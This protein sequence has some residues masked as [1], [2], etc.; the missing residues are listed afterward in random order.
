MIYHEIHHAAQTNRKND[1]TG[2]NQKGNL[3]RLI[4]E[5]QTQY[6]AEIVYQ[7]IHHVQFEN[8]QIPSE[9]SRM[10]KRGIIL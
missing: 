4:L 10:H 6:F 5:A 2:I 7:R 8:K 9:E 3:G 1:R